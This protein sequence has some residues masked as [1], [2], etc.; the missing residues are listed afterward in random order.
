MRPFLIG[1]FKIG[2]ASLLAGVVLSFL[3]ITAQSILSVIGLTPES[4]W[5]KT[6]GF[7]N[8]AVPNIALGAV[9]VLPVWLVT[10]I[11]LPPRGE[12]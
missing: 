8:W 1:V 9:I 12:D 4:L 11:F 2:L 6:L 10:D 5:Q 3:G 7:L